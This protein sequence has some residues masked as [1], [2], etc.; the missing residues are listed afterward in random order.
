MG[1]PGHLV[2]L[3]T[4]F[5]DFSGI[6]YKYSKLQHCLHVIKAAFDPPMQY[7]LQHLELLCE[8]SYA[9]LCAFILDEQYQKLISLYI[10][11]QLH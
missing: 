8:H 4:Q 1:L 2:L 3:G 6:G 9:F 11:F 5:Q 7:L 10:V